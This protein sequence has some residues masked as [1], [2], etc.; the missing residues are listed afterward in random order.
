MRR[1]LNLHRLRPLALSCIPDIHRL[2]IRDEIARSDSGT[3]MLPHARNSKEIW[4]CGYG[5]GASPGSVESNIVCNYCTLGQ[6]VSFASRWCPP[7]R[8][9]SPAGHRLRYPPALEWLFWLHSLLVVAYLFFN[10]FSVIPARKKTK[11]IGTISDRSP[12]QST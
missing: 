5:E 10:Y 11:Q 9:G 3:E 6:P 4:T 2:D 7:G 1:A 8:Q 12:P